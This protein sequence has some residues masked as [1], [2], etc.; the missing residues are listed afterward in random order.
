MEGNK[1][2]AVNTIII[3][4]R[5]IIVSL[6][7]IILS[8]VVL[9]ALGASDFGL[10]NVVGGIVILL[11]VLN[12]SM[13]ST[14]YRYLAFE[15]GKGD[16]GNTNKV[17]NTSIFIH[18]CFALLIFLVGLPIGDWYISNYMNIPDGNYSDAH[19]VFHL[20]IIAAAINTLLVPFQGLLVAYEKFYA[21]ERNCRT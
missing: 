7:N 10:Y 5:L 9:D 6:V 20:S 3:Y 16:E 1:K 14:T 4:V 21:K 15:L 12:T 18:A 2:I 13:A 17:F 11:N 19:F 8:R